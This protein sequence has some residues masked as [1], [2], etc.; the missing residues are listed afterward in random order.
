MDSKKSFIT[1]IVGWVFGIG[2]ISAV[3][4]DVDHPLWPENARF[5]HEI[6]AVGGL[7]AIL[8][9]GWLCFT[10]YRRLSGARILRRRNDNR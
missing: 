4:I 8:I 5:L 3:L 9:G 7:I 10:F 6:F 1:R 2:F